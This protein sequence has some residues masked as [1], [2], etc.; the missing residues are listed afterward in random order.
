[1]VGKIREP[2]VYVQRL[3]DLAEQIGFS[4]AKSL[5]MEAL[6]VLPEVRA[7]CSA[8]RCK[9]YDRSWSCPP[10]CG[11]LEELADRMKHYQS[12]ILVQTTAQMDDAFD[13]DAIRESER[14]H[15]KQF[16][17]LARQAR[18]LYP[19]CFPMGSGGCRRCKKCT[20]PTRPCRYPKQLYPSMEA[21]GLLVS[22]VCQKSGLTYYYGEKS[23]TYTACILIK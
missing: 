7:M 19:D 17:T 4:Q 2:D 16:D 10:A 1:M 12:G 18:Q 20:Y 3:L 6:E 22:E 21:C 15:K 14:H 13:L 5:N 11:S 8:D 23:I 9:N